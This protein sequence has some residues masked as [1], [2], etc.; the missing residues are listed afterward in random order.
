MRYLIGVIFTVLIDPTFAASLDEVRTLFFKIEQS[1]E[2]AS[3]LQLITSEEAMRRNHVMAG[4][5]AVATANQAQYT[6]IPTSKYR[7]FVQG[8]EMIEKAIHSEPHNAELRFLRL[9]MQV[10]TPLFLN[11]NQ[12]I[13]SD[14]EY[15]IGY[16]ERLDQFS[17]RDAWFWSKVL[18]YLLDRSRPDDASRVRINR[19]I[20]KSAERVKS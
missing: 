7:F 11:Y 15:I 3:Q 12:N 1:K 10:G 9:S 20:E 19:L 8:R 5:H 13:A 6:M 17:D 14:R 2:I 4:Y 16:L 18:L